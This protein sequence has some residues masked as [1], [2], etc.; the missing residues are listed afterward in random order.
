MKKVSVIRYADPKLKSDLINLKNSKE[1]ELYGFINNAF[2]DLELNAFCGV[3]IPKKQIPKEYIK[4]YKIDNCW[5]YNLPGAWRI[6]YSIVSKNEIE[7]I[8]LILEWIT[9]KDYERKFGYKRS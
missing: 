5:K 7:V 8:S 2:D 1:K 9:H 6:I 4:K 3:Q